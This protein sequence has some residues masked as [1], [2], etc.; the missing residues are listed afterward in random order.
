MFSRS[1]WLHVPDQP[2]NHKG[3]HEAAKN[4]IEK[5]TIINLLL[6]F[7]RALKHYLRG[8]DGIYYED[9]YPL[10]AYLPRY[11]LPSG[12]P[13][14]LVFSGDDDEDYEIAEFINLNNEGLPLHTGD[15]LTS[16][17][18]PQRSETLNTI[19]SSTN[20]LIRDASMNSSDYLKSSL[21]NEWEKQPQGMEHSEAMIS[22]TDT[23]QLLPAR[24]PPNESSLSWKILRWFIKTISLGTLGAKK[25]SKKAMR[26]A[27][28]DRVVSHNIPLEITIYLSSYINKLQRH[29]L[30]DDITIAQCFDSL[31]TLVRSLT[32]LERI[33]TTPIPWS[34]SFHIWTTT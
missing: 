9:L 5:R 7:S 21:S 28:Q 33:L 24:N 11:M 3:D 13:R 23:P 16:S 4:L 26:K 15:I 19:T 1:I 29:K 31:N 18:S 34:Y 17:P 20:T 10:I 27:L 6:A 8:E 25:S 14:P 30:A 2:H 12:I 22:E 32:G